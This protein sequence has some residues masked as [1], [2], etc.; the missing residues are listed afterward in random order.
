MCLC[1]DIEVVRLIGQAAF[2]SLRGFNPSGVTTTRAHSVSVRTHRARRLA[3]NAGSP[4]RHPQ[5]PKLTTAPRPVSNAQLSLPSKVLNPKHPGPVQRSPRL[6]RRKEIKDL[7]QALPR[8]PVRLACSDVDQ[9]RRDLGLAG[10]TC[11]LQDAVYV[12]I[13]TEGSH[14]VTEI[15]ISTLDTRDIIDIK[16]DHRAANWIA[17]IKHQHIIIGESDSLRLSFRGKSTLFCTSEVITAVDARAVVLARLQLARQPSL[18]HSPRK[19][20]L[21]GQSVQEDVNNLRRSPQVCL[22]LSHEPG[23]NF[24]FDNVYDTVKLAGAAKANG[25][26]FGGMSLGRLARSLGVD[27][28]YWAGQSVVGTHNA[29]NDASYTMMVMLLLVVRWPKLAEDPALTAT[30][31]SETP[32][33]RHRLARGPGRKIAKPT[34]TRRERPAQVK[35]HY[36]ETYQQAGVLGKFGLMLSRFLWRL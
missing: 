30:A 35:Q 5:Q 9:I 27:A 28:R 34:I 8:P 33:Y 19:V 11:K 12:A 6:Q 36:K 21:V 7:R 1:H 25:V 29:S 22:D 31:S 2:L 15:G 4:V 16:P 23:A 24:K 3:N 14:N 10:W 32:H 18:G 17:K 20:H 13:D 26:Q